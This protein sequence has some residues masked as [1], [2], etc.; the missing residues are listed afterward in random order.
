[1]NTLF[2]RT[3]AD[4]AL[5]FGEVADWE[6]A[7]TYLL[8]FA[9]KLNGLPVSSDSFTL[10]YRGKDHWYLLAQLHDYQPVEPALDL[11][12]FAQ[13]R[14]E[15]LAAIESGKASESLEMNQRGAIQ[16][17]TRVQLEYMP[18]SQKEKQ[19]LL[20]VWAVDFETAGQ[21]SAGRLYFSAQTGKPLVWNGNGY[22]L[23]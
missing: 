17:I 2:D 4:Y 22:Q 3:L 23:P 6:N 15:V 10:D 13:I 12:P 19:L 16:S 11:L 5:D 1:M 7:Q 8:C 9:P 21:D 18:F 14:Q 20:P